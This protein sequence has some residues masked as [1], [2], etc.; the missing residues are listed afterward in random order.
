MS[1][2][3]D[4]IDPGRFEELA[5]HLEKLAAAVEHVVFEFSLVDITVGEGVL[6]DA[7]LLVL[8]PLSVVESA[9]SFTTDALS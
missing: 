3:A 7:V 6:A 9:V 1:C 4:I 8:S 5:V 2:L